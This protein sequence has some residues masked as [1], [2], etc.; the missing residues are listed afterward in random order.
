MDKQS[1]N[2]SQRRHSSLFDVMDEQGGLLAE[3]FSIDDLQ[4]FFIAHPHYREMRRL[5]TSISAR[6]L[7]LV[8]AVRKPHPVANGDHHS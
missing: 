1:S 8:I 6:F 5:Q 3:A 7:V 4:A 2:P